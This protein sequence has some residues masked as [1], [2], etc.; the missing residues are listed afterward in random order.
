MIQN[1]QTLPAKPGPVL[2]KQKAVLDMCGIRSVNTLKK[3][4]DESGFPPPLKIDGIKFWVLAEVTGWIQNRIDV[5][6]R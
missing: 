6:A 2:I 4:I 3:R 5:A 1:Q